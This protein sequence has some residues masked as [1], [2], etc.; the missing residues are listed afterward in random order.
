LLQDDNNA[1]DRTDIFTCFTSV[2]KIGANQQIQIIYW[3][4]QIQ[5]IY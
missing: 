2:L 1:G 4:Q 3:A 5:V